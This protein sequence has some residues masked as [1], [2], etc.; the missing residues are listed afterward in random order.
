MANIC[1]N[2]IVFHSSNYEQLNLLFQ[3]IELTLKTPRKSIIDLIEI[4]GLA[5]KITVS[6]GRHQLSYCDPI[7]TEFNSYEFSLFTESAWV[8]LMEGFEELLK[9][10]MFNDIR[11]AYMSE[12]T[13]FGVFIKEDPFG[14]FF[15][16]N[17]RI[18]YNDGN[19]DWNEEYFDDLEDAVKF[20]Q[21]LFP[22]V[23][24]SL[25]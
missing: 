22:E 17:Y 1:I 10:P 8:P 9:Q 16:T 15:S 14:L 4:S 6:D 13:G 11:M 12:E 19:G 5:D 18:S 2:H 21:V 20:I 23:D 3:Y 7:G 25:S 24:V